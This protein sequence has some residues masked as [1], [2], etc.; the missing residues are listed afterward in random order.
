LDD[1]KILLCDLSKGAIGQ[2]NARLLGSLIAMQE[3]IA[4]LSRSDVPEVHRVPHML[5][6]EEAHN[7]IADFESILS[8]TRKF[9]LFLTT[10]TQGVDR[11]SKDTLSAIFNNAANLIAFRISSTDAQR[12]REE[13]SELYPDATLLHELSDFKAYVRTLVPDRNGVN[14]PTAP[15]LVSTYPPL[16]KTAYDNDRERVIRTSTERWTE[17]RAELEAKLARFLTRIGSLSEHGRAMKP[18]NASPDHR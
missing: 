9:A 7:F 12:L 4:A 15:H 1:R 11:L 6:I 14:T 8:E 17:P 3:K 13:F 16:P 2:G 18:H 5:Y 10:A